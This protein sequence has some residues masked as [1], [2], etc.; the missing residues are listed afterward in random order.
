M[1][2]HILPLRRSPDADGTPAPVTSPTGA[3]NPHTLPAGTIDAMS[4]ITGALLAQGW[5]GAEV[6]QIM[7]R[8]HQPLDVAEV[9]E[10]ASRLVSAA[11]ARLERA[12]LGFGAS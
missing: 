8:T 3:G 12:T 6:V 5:S 7:R 2:A 11:V 1:S 4:T 10:H 9:A